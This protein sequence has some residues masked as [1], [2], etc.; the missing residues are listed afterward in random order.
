MDIAQ[1]A[2]SGLVQGVGFRPF[3]YQLAQR[4]ALTG[5]VRNDAQGVLIEVAGNAT[6]LDDFIA[7]ITSNAPVLARVDSV[8][9]NDRRS[10]SADSSAN[11]QI[12]ASEG[13]S[14]TTVI[15]PDAVPCPDCRDEIKDSKARRWHYPFT[16]CTH[17]GPRYSII[18]AMP[19]D[20]PFTNMDVFQL[21]SDCATEYSDV[22]DRRFH[23]QPICCPACGP[24]FR[25]Y[26]AQQQQ[27]VWQQ[28]DI[29]QQLESL[30]L[31]LTA[32]DIAAI[33]GVGGYHLV[34]DATQAQAVAKLRQRK[35]RPSKPLAVMVKDIAM[36]STCAKLIPEAIAWLQHPSGCI[37]LVDKAPDSPLA[38]AIAP[39]QALVGLMLPMSPFHLLLMEKITVPLVFTSAN[40]SGEA[41]IYEDEKAYKNLIGMADWL[42]QHN[43]SIER[44]LEDSV[45]RVFCSFANQPARVAR[46][47]LGRGLSPTYITLPKGFSALPKMTAA[48]ADSKSA[49]AIAIGDYWCLS[50]HIGSFKAS[51]GD[52]DFAQVWQNFHRLY[53]YQPQTIVTDAH[54][55][56]VSTRYANTVATY[57]N[58]PIV[59]IY[60]H[61]AHLAACMADNQLPL[62]SPPVLGLILD[63]IG[64]G[65]GNQL[66][67]CELLYGHY[68]SSKR[69]ATLQ[70]SELIGGD[71]ASVQPWRNLL[72]R[73]TAERSWQ[74]CW[75]AWSGLACMQF[76]AQ[77]PIPL[78][79]QA[80]QKHLNTPLSH[81][82][83]RLFDAVAAA[84][85]LVP[86]QISYEGQAAMCLEALLSEERILSN[87]A[88]AY[89]FPIEMLSSGM[90]QLMTGQL[91]EQLMQDLAQNISVQ[92]IACRFHLG[93]AQGLAALV[94]MAHQQTG[95]NTVLLSGGVWQ[96]LW[97]VSLFRFYLP[98]T[99]TMLTHQQLPA[100]D[101]NIA[102]GQLATVG[103]NILLE[104]KQSI[105]SA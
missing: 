43:R 73:L 90:M 93:F 92:D 87:Q 88:F 64:L 54:Q 74:D 89:H 72:A 52:D 61:H 85:M 29:N 22:Q 79:L 46:M 100:H 105:R 19:Y 35:S 40:L 24:E 102:L 97:L 14:P 51:A 42:W 98:Q 53:D 44:R 10:I 13:G 55:G 50:Q 30:S 80:K 66:W 49:I 67:G 65:E 9:I 62:D 7:A 81:S 68:Q 16:N 84:L 91:F 71:V 15:P 48:G 12:I 33:K 3:I 47:R 2:V 36:A 99:I 11:F 37:V 6:Q 41:Q 76:L 32:G 69:I 31:A 83:G 59:P 63:G 17:C 8:Y 23:A 1:I 45:V 78:L 39:D 82:A 103:A 18:K 21:C 26:H 94:T 86:E 75:Q 77:K 5:W 57:S 20:R 70:P 34:C 38:A 4:H 27:W 56:Y 58:I 60:H 104:R 25:L 95:A 96:N 28:G 101:G